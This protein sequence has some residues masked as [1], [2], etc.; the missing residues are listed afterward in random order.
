MH[1]VK[2]GKI[3]GVDRY[4]HDNTTVGFIWMAVGI[5]HESPSYVHAYD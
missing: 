3:I 4:V 2:D 1:I 5:A